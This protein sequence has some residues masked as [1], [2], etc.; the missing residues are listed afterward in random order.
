MKKFFPIFLLIPLMCGCSGTNKG[1]GGSGGG[2]GGGQGGEPAV[3][4]VV[5]VN[6]Y[7]DFNQK[8]AKNI[9]Y[10]QKVKFGNKVVEPDHPTTPSDPAYPVFKGWSAKEI[11]DDEADLF[12]FNTILTEDNVSYTKVLDIF[13]IWVAQGE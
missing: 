12:D 10:V 4:E 13:G 5:T 8:P 3:E 9:Y 7:A 2:G 6:F 1:G 11:I